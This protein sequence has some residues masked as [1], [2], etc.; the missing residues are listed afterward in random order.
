MSDPAVFWEYFQRNASPLAATFR[1]GVEERAF[2]L[3]GR[4]LHASGFDVGF[5]LELDHDGTCILVFSPEGDHEAGRR[6][7]ALIAAAPGLVPGW[8]VHARKPRK[9]L[10]AARSLIRRQYCIDPGE[11]RYTLANAVGR[12]FVRMF[13]PPG[14]DLTDQERAGL[15]RLFLWNAV[16]ESVVMDL[17]LQAEAVLADPPDSGTISAAELVDRL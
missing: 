8:I 12:P 16:G 7:D 14:T 10:S 15:V 13:I 4:A 6:I 3:I 11:M 2:A 5:D 1:K 9:G 17:D